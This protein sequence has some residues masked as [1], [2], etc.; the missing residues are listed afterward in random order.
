MRKDTR[1]GLALRERSWPGDPLEVPDVLRELQC[2]A[3]KTLEDLL[4]RAPER[5][6]YTAIVGSQA[7]GTATPESD[8]DVHGLFVLPANK[9]L[10]LSPPAE[11][12]G[13]DRSN[14]IYYSLR[15]AL[16]LLTAANPNLLELL[17]L[18][19]DCVLRSS[20]EMATLLEH[21]HLF[22]SRRCADTH[23]SYARAQI[24]RARGQ[25]KWINN[26][27]PEA[28]PRREDFCYVLP[29]EGLGA[30]PASTAPPARPVPLAKLGWDLSHFHAARVEHAQELFRLYSYGPEARG[31]FR[32]DELV[33]TSIPKEDEVPRFAGLLLYSEPAFE[34]ALRDHKNYWQWRA[35]RNEARWKKQEQGELDYDAK[36]LMHTVR[37]LLSGRSILAHGEPIVRFEGEPLDLLRRIRGGELTYDEILALA[38]DLIRD[39]ESL[40]GKS[41]LPPNADP[42]RVKALLAELT[43]S[44]EARQ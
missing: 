43:A 4:E 35:H 28:P 25:N 17:F 14:V 19:A 27:K 12:L 7:Y 6:L 15:R 2:D 32:I 5:I 37:L 33:C 21:R 39:C 36:N 38:D 8:E 20:P 29:R 13:D 16:E 22:L 44:W 34:Q 24:K 18:P 11:Q 10:A 30:A 23:V 3:V 31:V 26:P 40:A 9:Y 42:V 1:F 41:D